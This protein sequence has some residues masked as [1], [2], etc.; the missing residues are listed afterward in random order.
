MGVRTAVGG[1]NRTTFVLVALATIACG[2][3]DA[4]GDTDTQPTPPPRST[5][6]MPAAWAAITREQFEQ[7]VNTTLDFD[8]G[9]G[10]TG[11]PRKCRATEPDCTSGPTPNRTAVDIH[12]EEGAR[13]LDPDLLGPNGHA[14]ARL[15]NTGGATEDRY[16]IPRGETVYWLVTP[17]P[18][19]QPDVSTFVYFQGNVKRELG[20]FPYSECEDGATH[21]NTG[22]EANFTRC[23]NDTATVAMNE[24]EDPSWISCLEG[25]CIAGIPNQGR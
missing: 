5:P 25:C 8:Q 4:G 24:A 18:A 10:R 12:P 19:G 15:R 9:G 13:E 1:S 11:V 16:G 21:P 3:E 22:R 20:P 23:K 7:Y 17:G 14:I 6:E 2:G